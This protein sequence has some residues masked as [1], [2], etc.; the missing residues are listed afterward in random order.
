MA[1]GSQGH[2]SSSPA[3]LL[4]NHRFWECPVAQ[5]V[6]LVLQHNL[7]PN[8]QLQAHHLLL[9]APPCPEVQPVVWAVVTLAALTA[10]HR[11]QLTLLS[12]R[13]MQHI[14]AGQAAREQRAH[15]AV[16][17]QRTLAECGFL[18]VRQPFQP[19]APPP[20]LP[21]PHAQ[22]VAQPGA[23]LAVVQ[24]LSNLDDFVQLG[25]C[26]GRPWATVLPTH[27]FLGVADGHGGRKLVVTVTTPP[28]VL[29]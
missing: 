18:P 1:E 2:P 7:P 26:S 11:T 17:R 24:L 3:A 23:R 9:A 14:A 13:R 12:Q 16:G 22:I 10:I 8:T 28:G 5:A 27:P 29:N 4:R 20:P 6:R 15:R 21:A 19:A 25:C